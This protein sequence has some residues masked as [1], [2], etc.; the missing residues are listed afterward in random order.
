MGKWL[1]D[2][3]I[4]VTFPRSGLNYFAEYF[5]QATNFYLPRSHFYKRDENREVFSIV[6]SPIDTIVSGVSQHINSKPDDSIERVAKDTAKEYFMFYNYVINQKVRN[7]ISY[8][9]FIKDPA[10]TIK[11]FSNC[12]D[13]ENVSID[14]TNILKPHHDYVPSSKNLEVYSDVLM[15]VKTLDLS[16]HQ[17][18][19]Q[20]SLSKNILF[21]KR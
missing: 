5:E 21:N 14:Y 13:L 11:N 10:N 12:L 18:E 1:L 15:Y 19:Y 8:N 3:I 16:I 9:D 20:K 17:I 6:R 4:F 7:I 2:N